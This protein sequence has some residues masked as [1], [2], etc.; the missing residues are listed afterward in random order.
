MIKATDLRKGNKVLITRDG[1]Q[2]IDTVLGVLP[3]DRQDYDPIPITADILSNC[4]FVNGKV[5]AMKFADNKVHPVGIGV[6]HHSEMVQKDFST[7]YVLTILEG[8]TPTFR[9][10]INYLHELQNIFHA[11]T[12]E[13][14]D[15]SKII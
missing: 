15:V 8:S 4:G 13:E 7:E 9:K 6:A 10:G 11:I 3:D 14:L 2:H 5:Y 1:K 12:N